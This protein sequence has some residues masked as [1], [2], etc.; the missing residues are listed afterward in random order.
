MLAESFLAQNQVWA[1]FNPSLDELTVFMK[2]K[3]K[4]ALEW[5]W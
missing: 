1:T 3:A 2:A 5:Q 4:E